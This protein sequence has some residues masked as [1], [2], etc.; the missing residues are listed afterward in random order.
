MCGALYVKLCWAKLVHI[1]ETMNTLTCGS[2]LPRWSAWLQ[3]QVT[4]IVHLMGCK[5]LEHN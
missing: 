3:Q 5:Y 4:V 2:Q 1:Q